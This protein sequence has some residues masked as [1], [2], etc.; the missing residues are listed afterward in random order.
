ELHDYFD[1]LQDNYDVRVVV[2][3]GAGRMFC[4]GLDM[5]DHGRQPATGTDEGMIGQRNFSGLVMKM[6]RAPQ[7]MIGLLHGYAAG[8]GFS[9]ALGCDVR[10]AAEGTKMNCAFIKIGLSG[11]EMGSSY[12]L[13]R[14]I[15]LSNAAELLYTGRFINADRA[16]RTGLISDVVPE[17]E[18]VATGKALADDM[19]AT[20]PLGLRLT[21]EAYWA[22][23]DVQSLDAAIAMEDRNQILTVANGDLTEGIAAFL[24]KREP[25]WTKQAAGG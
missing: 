21:K 4:A 10:I 11:C 9:I 22:N 19:V 13:P 20:A 15:G 12:H 24:D 6:R 25:D 1:G 8:G 18:L 23:V 16:L 5:K 14:L 7:P 3:R 2:I 17:A